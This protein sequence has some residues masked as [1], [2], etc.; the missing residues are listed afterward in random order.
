MRKRL[1]AVLVA[2]ALGAGGGAAGIAASAAS[3]GTWTCTNGGGNTDQG[4]PKCSGEVLTRLNP[5]GNQPPGQQ[6]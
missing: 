3:A 5:A 4:R 1:V 6:P 2:A